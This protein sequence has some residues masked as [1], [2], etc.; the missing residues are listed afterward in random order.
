MEKAADIESEFALLFV[1]SAP[2]CH[3]DQSDGAI[4]MIPSWA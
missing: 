3:P 2:T 4:R 1:L